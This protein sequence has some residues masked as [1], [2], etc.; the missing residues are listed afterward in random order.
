MNVVQFCNRTGMDPKI[1]ARGFAEGKLPG[2][3]IGRHYYI[4]LEWV[5]RWERGLDGFWSPNPTTRNVPEN[6][7]IRT[8]SS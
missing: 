4:R 2:V 7:Y 8:A 1:A 3:K 5:E 6:P